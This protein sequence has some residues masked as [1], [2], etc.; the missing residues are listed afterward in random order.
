MLVSLLVALMASPLMGTRKRNAEK[1][2]GI[3][4]DSMCYHLLLIHCHL[5]QR[6]VCARR[7]LSI[8]GLVAL[9]LALLSGL[10]IREHSVNKVCDAGSLPAG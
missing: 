3:L 2:D 4:N 7:T 6:L 5:C 9:V 8:F 1:D 10:P